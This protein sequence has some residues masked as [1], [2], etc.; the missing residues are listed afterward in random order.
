[1]PKT[2]LQ[3]KFSHKFRSLSVLLGISAA[4]IARRA[5]GKHLAPT[6]GIDF[7]IANLFFR[8]QFNHALSL[9][10]MAEGRAYFDSL[11][12]L[13]DLKPE[14][15]IT[16]LNRPDLKGEWYTPIHRKHPAT[17]LHLHGGGYSFYGIVSK[18]FTA[19]MAHILGIPIFAP[20]YRLTPEHPHPAQ[21]EDAVRSYHYL[22]EQAVDPENLIISGDSAGGHLMLMLLVKLRELGLAQPALGIGISPWTD[23]GTRGPSLFGN[24]PYDLV[25]GYMTQRFAAALK[26]NG[27]FTDQE[28]SPIHQ[29]LRGLA[30]IYLQAGG[31]EILVDMIRDFAK[32]AQAQ[33]ASVRLDVWPEMTHEFQ[34]Y[35]YDLA[36]SRTAFDLLEN[37]IAA[38]LAGEISKLLSSPYTETGNFSHANI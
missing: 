5:M 25:Q 11:Y 18:H 36:D 19:L 30:P 32:E 8:A 15:K 35:G 6:W 1:M 24:D 17:M 34:T 22:M 38:A 2:V 26:G 31:R 23:V 10:T 14:V 12:F 20:D 29:N 9:P 4:V 16:T 21:I 28:L 33:G 3:G 7:E 27:H 13:S 37:A